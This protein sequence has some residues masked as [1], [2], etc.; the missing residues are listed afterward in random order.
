MLAD[1]LQ[2]AC[3]S[4]AFEASALA[5]AGEVCDLR[6]TAQEGSQGPRTQRLVIRI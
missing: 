1:C 4:K 3:Q 5:G 2:Y 6:P